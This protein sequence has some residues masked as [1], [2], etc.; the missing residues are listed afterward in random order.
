M[1]I[2]A[3]PLLGPPPTLR[4]VQKVLSSLRLNEFR[5]LRVLGGETTDLRD[6]KGFKLDIAGSYLLAARKF[7]MRGELYMYFQDGR[8]LQLL[9]MAVKPGLDR[10]KVV[11]DK[12]RKSIRF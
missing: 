7:E 9:T 5:D 2:D 8:Y 6:A 11:Y 12:I 3:G 10:Q 1:H 4:E